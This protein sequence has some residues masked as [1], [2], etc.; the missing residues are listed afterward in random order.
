MW[1]DDDLSKVLDG[2]SR[3]GWLVLKRFSTTYKPSDILAAF[4]CLP[5]D[6]FELLRRLHFALSPDTEHFLSVHVPTFLRSIPST[7]EHIVQERR[8]APRGRIDWSRTYLRRTQSGGDPSHFVT[9][10]IERTADSVAARA[11]AHMLARIE[12]NASWLAKRQLPELARTSVENGAVVA[13]KGLA[14]LRGRGVRIPTRL[15]PRDLAPIRQS[16][17][18]DVIATVRLYDLFVSLVELANAS[19]LGTLLRGRQMAPENLD[20]LFE[21][22]TLLTFIERHI[23]EGWEIVDARLIGGEGSPKRPKFVLQKDGRKA[24]IYYQTVPQAIS[25]SS[26]YKAIFDDYDLDVA[27]R[28]PDITWEVETADGVQTMIVEVKRTQDPGYIVDSVYKTLGY[29]ADFKTVIGPSMPMA[30]LVVWKGVAAT[31]SPHVDAPIRILTAD[32]FKTLSL[33]H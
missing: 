6:D 4:A 10:P 5:S 11:V 7:T 28:R 9:R 2:V 25:K 18:L 8:D 23:D 1:S 3:L 33:P 20:D 21:I 24:E 17:R 19:L 31:K 27:Q 22:W 16:R 15:L 30:L 12:Q 32:D 13:R 14:N 26:V 29:I